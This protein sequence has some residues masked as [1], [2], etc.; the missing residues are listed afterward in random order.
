[1]MRVVVAMDSFKGCLTSM[2]AGAAV[3][4]GIMAAQPQA[5]VTVCPL[6][7]GGEGTVDALIGG[8]GGQRVT[9]TVTGP[10]GE[11]A[12]AVYALLPGGTA[13]MEMAA[14]AGLTLV[15]PGQRDPLRATTRGVGELIRHAMHS[16]CR[17]FLL[18]IGGSATNDGGA[19][20][21]QALG[22]ALTDERGQPI[23][24]GAQ[25]LA[26]LAHIS[27]ENALPALRE[28]TFTV[29]CDVNNPLCGPQ[30]ASAVF[31]PQKGA[32][33]DV[34]AQLDSLLARFAGLA[35]E[36]GFPAA[37]DTPGAGAAGG[38]GFALMTFLGA[39]LRSGSAIVTELT[40]LEEHIRTAD[41]VITGEGRLDGQTA[42]GKGPGA[43]AALAKRY[44]KPVIA[45]AGC[46]TEEADA[47]LVSG[48]DAFFPI[49]P[50]P[51]TA[52]E[53]MEPET[54]ARNLERTA[55]QVF[56][57]LALG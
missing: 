17:R 28:C 33:K 29:A 18:G 48:I 20:M 8:L 35:A 24:D 40:H 36:E 52:E 39:S 3:R 7:D 16:G 44:G 14:A 42:M 5:Y 1:M 47:C 41:M 9:V 10:L 37:P 26:H 31:G 27:A 43:V 22:F 50:G 55:R 25:G 6:A 57:L 30:G 51:A 23:P 45:L 46:V 32:T 12:E 21:L 13:V 49:L 19:G 34:A 53:A 56:R 2:E 54:A 38:L 4:R 15:P 11:P